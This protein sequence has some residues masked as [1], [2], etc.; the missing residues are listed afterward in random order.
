[1][2]HYPVAVVVAPVT[3]GF[4]VMVAVFWLVRW[5]TR[6]QSVLFSLLGSVCIAAACLVQ[7]DPR[8]GLVG[9]SAFAVLGAYITFFHAA[10]DMLINLS[11]A[12]STSAVLAARL[13]PYYDAVVAGSDSSFRGSPLAFP[14]AVIGSCIRRAATCDI[15]S[16]QLTGLLIRRAFYPSAFEL[17][18]RRRDGPSIWACDG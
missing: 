7:G 9:C 13:I 18:L 4:G 6:G 3:S 11:I 2:P 1:M 12:I 17:L 14:F 16:Q 10:Q 15:P 5:P 8:L